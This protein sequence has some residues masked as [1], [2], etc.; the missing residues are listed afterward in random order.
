MLSAMIFTMQQIIIIYIGIAI[1][2]FHG[3]YKKKSSNS[4]S[5]QTTNSEM[6]FICKKLKD[7]HW[8]CVSLSQDS[9]DEDILINPAAN[10]ALSGRR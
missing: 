3:I 7:P 9:S 5:F 8:D 4:A 10:R 6:S 1:T 2:E